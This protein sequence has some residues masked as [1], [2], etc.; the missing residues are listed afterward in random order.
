MSVCRQ[1]VA[2]DW[3]LRIPPAR[4]MVF[5]MKSLVLE[6]PA[7]VAEAMRLPDNEKSARLRLEL[8]ISL[9]SQSI[10]GLGKAAQLAGMARWELNRVLAERG[11]A[12]HY[13]AE[14]LTEDVA[15]GCG[16]Q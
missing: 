5:H 13:G 3:P 7:E 9:Y 15:H 2:W 4:G 10:L 8:A 16:G 12:L 11:V 14:E 6:I 1:Q